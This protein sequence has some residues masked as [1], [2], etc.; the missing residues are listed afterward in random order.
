[1]S[2][3]D[4]RSIPENRYMVKEYEQFA[5]M[6]GMDVNR[7]PEKATGREIKK[8]MLSI[9]ERIANEDLIPINIPNTSVLDDDTEYEFWADIPEEEQFDRWDSTTESYFRATKEAWYFEGDC[10]AQQFSLLFARFK[11]KEKQCINK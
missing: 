3:Y 2:S 9:K 6:Y 11:Q 8:F 10:W 5:N 4:W 1:M 7:I